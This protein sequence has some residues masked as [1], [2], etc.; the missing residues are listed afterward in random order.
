MARADKM[1]TFPT[2]KGC[3]SHL[4]AR[5]HGQWGRW[6]EGLFGV[7]TRPRV[8]TSKPWLWG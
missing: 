8:I 6:A 5:S 4:N 2:F 7:G 3:D 1:A